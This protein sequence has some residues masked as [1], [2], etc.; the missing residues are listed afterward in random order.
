[1][2]GFV[3][4]TLL[5]QLLRNYLMA[6]DFTICMVMYGSGP[7]MVM[8]VFFRKLRSIHIV[9]DLILVE[10]GEAEDMRSFLLILG[11]LVVILALHSVEIVEL[12]FE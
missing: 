11:H 1:M 3:T 5:S 9:I 8:A 12:V 10:S 7:L 6:L 4:Q 2:L